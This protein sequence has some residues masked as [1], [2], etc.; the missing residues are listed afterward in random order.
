MGCIWVEWKGGASVDKLDDRNLMMKSWKWT[1]KT[2]E[3][4]TEQAVQSQ[5]CANEEMLSNAR[6]NQYF[7]MVML[8]NANIKRH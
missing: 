2:K 7:V 4:K 6:D 1:I 5:G 3:N 8:M